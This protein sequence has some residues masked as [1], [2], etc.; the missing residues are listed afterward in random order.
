MFIFVQ[1]YSFNKKGYLQQILF[2]LG[3]SPFQGCWEKQTFWLFLNFSLRFFF[4]L[5]RE[6]IS[7]IPWKCFKTKGRHSL[8]VCGSFWG[9]KQFLLIFVP[10]YW[11]DQKQ[12]FK[13][14]Q[15]FLW[16]CP[17]SI[18]RKAYLP[19][20]SKILSERVKFLIKKK[21]FSEFPRKCFKTIGKHSLAVCG[22]FWGD[23][24]W[25]I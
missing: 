21:I 20:I 15:I 17:F 22:S 8:S 1:F 13:L 2:S 9:E 4:W 25:L 18:L 10:L 6:V 23:F 12:L 16:I 14:I 19:S 7:D 3:F 24:F 11:F 5:K